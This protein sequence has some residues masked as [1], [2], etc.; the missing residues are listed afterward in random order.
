MFYWMILFSILLQQFHSFSAIILCRTWSFIQ[1]LNKSWSISTISTLWIKEPDQHAIQNSNKWLWEFT[2]TNDSEKLL[3]Q[4]TPRTYSEN[5]S[6]KCAHIS[7]MSNSLSRNHRP[8]N[9]ILRPVPCHK[10]MKTL[11]WRIQSRCLSKSLSTR[12]PLWFTSEKHVPY[13]QELWL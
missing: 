13:G 4:M 12:P 3:R 6:L 10:D 11:I 5:D 2:Q 7:R 9:K 1:L 8:C